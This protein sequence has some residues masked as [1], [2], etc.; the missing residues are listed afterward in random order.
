MHKQRQTTPLL[1]SPILAC[2]KAIC[3]FTPDTKAA[4][5]CCFPLINPQPCKSFPGIFKVQL[6]IKGCIALTELQRQLLLIQNVPLVVVVWRHS[7]FQPVRCLSGGSA[8]GSCDFSLPLPCPCSSQ[9]LQGYHRTGRP[10][11][12]RGFLPQLHSDLALCAAQRTLQCGFRLFHLTCCWCADKE[13]CWCPAG[14]VRCYL[15]ACL[16]V[17]LL[18]LYIGLVHTNLYSTLI[19]GSLPRSQST[20][21]FFP[22]F[23]F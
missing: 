8:V 6:Q 20:P 9:L 11:T 16:P 13:R 17:L 2:C 23:L 7:L 10:L 3:A 4:R 1:F 22:S 12:A 15:A 21:L 18:I 5:Q 14:E 19:C